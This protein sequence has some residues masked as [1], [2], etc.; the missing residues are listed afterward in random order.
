MLTSLIFCVIFYEQNACDRLK[1]Y[2]VY[3]L[4]RAVLKIRS[5]H[6]D[7]II[8]SATC[9]FFSDV[10]MLRMLFVLIQPHG[11]YITMK[12]AFRETQTLRAGCSKFNFLAPPQTP[13][14]GVQDG[15]NLISRRWSLPSPTDPVWWRSMH[16]FS[17]YR[18]NRP[19]NK[20]T[21]KDT[22]E[23]TGPITIHCAAKVSARCNKMLLLLIVVLLLFW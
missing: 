23:Q 17:S 12:K 21:N 19:T 13:F 14:P 10:Y 15:E 16:A 22:L 9:R 18:G 20:H 5:F 8:F 11:C 3:A 4:G 1:Y 7:W 6:T 2:Q